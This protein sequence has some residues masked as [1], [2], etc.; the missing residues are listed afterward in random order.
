MPST[1]FIF[2]FTRFCREKYRISTRILFYIASFI[3][4]FNAHRFA[5][6]QRAASFLS[7][8]LFSFYIYLGDER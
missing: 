8:P 3:F 7:V 6:T 1:I 5:G 4:P 2:E